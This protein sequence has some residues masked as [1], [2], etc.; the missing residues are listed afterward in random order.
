[1]LPYVKRMPEQCAARIL[2]KV[3]GMALHFLKM[4]PGSQSCRILIILPMRSSTI[5]T[6]SHP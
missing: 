3:T 5:A 2:T 4:M 1:M 6:E